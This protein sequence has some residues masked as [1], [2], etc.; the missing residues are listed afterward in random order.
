MNELLFLIHSIF[1]AGI[2]LAAAYLGKEALTAFVAI[3]CILANLFVIKQITLFGMHVTATDA[4]IIGSVLAM[5]LL[6]EYFGKENAQKALWVAFSAAAFF[7][8][9]AQVHLAY[10]PNRFDESHLLFVQIFNATPRII[11]A[12]LFSYFASQRFESYFYTFLKEKLSGNYLIVRNYLSMSCS[13][14][15]DTI[16][17]S[18]LGL[19]GIVENVFD[20]ILVSYVIKLTAIIIVSPLIW[21]SKFYMKRKAHEI[22]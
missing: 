17:F 6:N 10:L 20:I 14:L 19:Y 8:I 4:Y 18:F 1:I 5:N 11:L 21:L 2:A 9:L 3:S 22:L 7:A 12:S 16:L 15:L 13:Q